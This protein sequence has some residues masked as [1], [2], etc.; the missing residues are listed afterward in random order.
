VG[1]KNVKK[2]VEERD[3]AP[4]GLRIRLEEGRGGGCRQGGERGGGIGGGGRGRVP[5]G[6]V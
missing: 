3:L 1:K 4:G 6:E 2:R 5:E